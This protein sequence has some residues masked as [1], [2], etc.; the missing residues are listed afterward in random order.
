MIV[1]IITVVLM[2]LSKD[3]NVQAPTDA[4]SEKVEEGAAGLTPFQD[5]T[6]EEAI[7][8]LDSI[9]SGG[10]AG[11]PAGYVDKEITDPIIMNGNVIVSDLHLIYSYDDLAEVEEQAR[12]RYGTDEFEVKE[13]DHYAI[14]TPEWA[15]GATSCDH[16]YHD[17]CDS[18]IAFKRE[19][20]NFVQEEVEPQS[21]RDTFYI[22]S[23]DPEVVNELM[24][25]F[26]FL[27]TS[28]GFSGGRG[29]IYSYEFEEQEDKFVLTVNYIGVGLNPKMLEDSS[30]YNQLSDA[31]A[32]NLFSYYYAVDKS[33]GR[34]YTIPVR[35]E[36]EVINIDY[37]KSF[38]I[39]EEEMNSLIRG[40]E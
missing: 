4:G 2:N 24:R 13:Y 39:T 22:D 35:T 40:A 32:I 8:F 17:D 28:I 38:P 9:G 16:G 27:G 14:V 33:D 20:M 26:T 10:D 7:A 21:Y 34:V 19:Y 25:A 15:K 18:L 5:L 31:Y 6:K 3:N 23:R 11:L 36:P 1:G 37:I 29:N 12:R 30:S